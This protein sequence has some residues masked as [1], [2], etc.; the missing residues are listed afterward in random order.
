[1]GERTLY[2][3]FGPSNAKSSLTNGNTS[4]QSFNSFAEEGDSILVEGLQ[5]KV[6]RPFNGVFTGADKDGIIGGDTLLQ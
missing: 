6:E 5:F 1:M 2:E 4:S 3:Q